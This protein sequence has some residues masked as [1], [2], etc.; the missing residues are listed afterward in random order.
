MGSGELDAHELGTSPPGY[1]CRCR[2]GSTAARVAAVDGELGPYRGGRRRRGS[3]PEVRWLGQLRP[4]RGGRRHRGGSLEVPARWLRQLR[5]LHPAAAPD[6]PD[7]QAGTEGSEKSGGAGGDIR[8][9]LIEVSQ[10]RACRPSHASPGWMGSAPTPDAGVWR[11]SW[12]AGEPRLRPCNRRADGW[13]HR[14]WR[15]T[16]APSVSRMEPWRATSLAGCHGGIGE[17]GTRE[18]V[19]PLSFPAT[20]LDRDLRKPATDF[21]QEYTSPRIAAE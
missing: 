9:R 6:Q 2:G 13:T 5:P 20:L 18:R 3:P 11:P 4:H 16:R 1:C 17:R 8:G 7:L 15:A 14:W 10:T 19:P 12:Y 21:R